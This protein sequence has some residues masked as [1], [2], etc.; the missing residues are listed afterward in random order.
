MNASRVLERIVREATRRPLATV[1]AVAVLAVAGGLFALS[2]KP[3]AGTD[4]LV[5]KGSDPAKST[6]QL[7]DRFGDDPVIVL[8]RAPLTKLVLTPDLERLIGFEGCISGNIPTRVTPP[9]GHNGPC[10]RLARSKPVK[11][12]YGPGTF[13]NES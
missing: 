8:V 5:G 4:T 11:V 10:A 3:D 6:R 1:A 12:V 2:L 7:H 13:V 9:G